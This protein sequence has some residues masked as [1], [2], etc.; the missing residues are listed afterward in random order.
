MK[1]ILLFC[2]SLLLMGSTLF[3]QTVL[4]QDSFENGG[5]IPPGW[6]NTVLSGSSTVV[7]FVTTGNTGYPSVTVNPYDLSYM[8]YYNAYSITSGTTLLA[9]TANTST[10]GYTNITM[11]FA[12]Y[13]DNGYSTDNDEITPEYSIDNGTTWQ[14]AGGPVLRYAATNYW[15]VSSFSLPAACAGIANLRIAFLFT[16]YFGNNIFMDL[17]HISGTPSA[18]APTVTT[19]AA[20]AVLAYSATL[21]GTVNANGSSTTV[22]FQYGLTVAY[23]STVTATQSPVTGSTATAV[24][25]PI[26]G[27]TAN[28]LYHFRCVGT[29]A[30]GTTNGL[31]MTFTT[32]NAPPI[33]V[34]TAATNVSFNSA[35]LNGTVNPNGASSTVS[36][37]YG[38]TVAYGTTVAGTPS[39][40][41]G[42]SPVA[43]SVNI[44]A[45]TPGTLYHYRVNGVNAGGTTHG[46]DMTFTTSA[47]PPLVVT[48]AATGVAGTSATLNGTVNANSAPTT[49][50]F[51]YG[52]TIPYA[53]TVAGNPA[54]LNGSAAVAINASLTGLTNNSV[55]HFRAKATNSGGT[56]FGNDLTFVLGCPAAGPAGAISGPS[57]VCQG[58]NGYVYF[59]PTIL[60]ATGY[61]WTLPVG[62]VFVSGFNTNSITVNYAFNAAPGYIFVYGT[63]PCGNGSPSQLAITVNPPASPTISGPASVCVGSTGNT[64]TTQ[65]GMSGYT[66]TV[67]G[68]G[69]I[70]G[71][72]TTGSN[73][74]TVTWNTAG[75]QTVSVNYNNANGCA[76]LSATVYNIT[77]NALPVPTISGPA[78]ACTNVSSVYTT[79]PGMTNYTWGISGGGTIQSGLGT[80]SITVV[81]NTAGAQSLSVNYN[82]AAGCTAAS[83]TSLPV[84]V[85]ATTVPVITGPNTACTGSGYTNY[86]TQA[87]MTAY[88]WNVSSG[89]AIA[90]GGGT[91]SI[92]VTWNTAGAQW[93]SVNFINPSGCSPTSPTQ[94]NVTVSTTPGAAG[95]I[96]G[97][98][99]VCAGAQ[100]VAY[101]VGTITNA[102]TYV[103]TLP[104]GATI[105]T[106]ANSNSITVNY[107]ATATSGNITVYGNDICGNGTVSPPFPVT[108]N[109]LPANA[110]TITGPAALCQGATGVVYTVPAITNATGYMWT[111]PT[112]ATIMSGANTNTITVDFGATATSGNITV[113][114]TNSCGNGVVS[115]NF[116]VTVNPIPPTPVVTN[117]GTTLQSTAASGNQWYFEGTLITG[118]TGQT[119]VATQDGYYWDIVTLNG[120]SSDS[121]NHKLILTTGIDPHSSAAINIYPVPNNGQFNVSINTA[122][123]QSFSISVYNSIGVRI[124]EEPKVDVNGSLQK[125]IDLRPVPEGVYTVIFTNSQN[126][127]VKKIVVSK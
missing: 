96:T 6:S 75:S 9:R 50:W 85:N 87:G 68:G 112:G 116:A 39:P 45:L 89:G 41:T 90:Y 23:G 5:S 117:T 29:N 7:T 25:A 22:T 94:Y 38:L 58:G 36:F 114:G 105:A 13:H 57:S 12:M 101:S 56:T 106:G 77:V 42:N 67:S 21:N 11:D 86:S 34:T 20:S 37:D 65:A 91:N 66:W 100:G 14:V 73:T 76:G 2:V 60:N 123:D 74:V 70:T 118:A 35:T 72:G 61:V 54:N 28:T 1:K 119:Y 27:L 102:T 104:T 79:Q 4:F 83:P 59:V 110:G 107:S 43:V 97:T 122:S 18:V 55:Y 46:N 84:T 64:Y 40:V 80:S 17:V 92:S 30:G 24:S 109:P 113:M 124:Y 31:D 52:L 71:G 63:G 78:P 103:W 26:A 98:A 93:V 111:V 69:S 120:C 48:L 44:A 108:V 15:S 19:N 33:V 95:S 3:S 51:D 53:F 127:V 99:T 126:Q 32:A 82:N 62:A 115:P 16:S 88:N 8:V 125:V 81:W 49:T 10:V 121:S 47:Q